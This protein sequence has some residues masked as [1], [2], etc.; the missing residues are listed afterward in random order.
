MSELVLHHY[1]LS[2]YS[3]KIRA[4]FGLKGLA[5]KSVITPVQMPKPDLLALTGGY[6]KAPVLQIGRGHLL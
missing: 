5:W 4:I 1:P 2:P 3:E 6:R